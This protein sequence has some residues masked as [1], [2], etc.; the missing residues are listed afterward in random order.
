MPTVYSAYVGTYQPAGKAALFHLRFDVATGKLTIQSA[1]SSVTHP[2]FLALHPTGH[3]LYAASE[4]PG[5]AAGEICAFAIDPSSG[6]LTPLHRRPAHGR[7]T[8]HVS[9]DATGRYLVAANYS[10]PTIVMYPL[11][12]DGTLGES[13]IL[14]THQGSSVH[15]RQTEPHPHSVNIDPTNRFVYCPDLGMDKVMVYR[16]DA[17]AGTLTPSDPPFAAAAPGAGPRH[18]AFH[19]TLPLAYAV[20]EIDSTVAAYGW[21]RSSGALDALQVVST[22]PAGFQGGS[23]CADIHLHPSGR[24]LYASNRGHDSIAIYHVD[25]TTGRLTPAGHAPTQGRTPRN[26]ALDP[27]GTFLFAEN[28]DSD[29]IVTFR[30]DPA[31]GAL[32][33]TG[34]VTHVP[35]PVCM[36]FRAVPT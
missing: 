11:Q 18:L 21:D 1:V 6:D 16:L 36:K 3:V 9:V 8:C 33:A 13:P 14:H 32:H 4:A 24:F 19:P 23:S 7:S 25:E 34:E 5:G 26:F 20:N 12:Q 27:T 28:Q 15:A 17:A 29:T 31:T 30:I 22:L 10:S 2:S 35:T